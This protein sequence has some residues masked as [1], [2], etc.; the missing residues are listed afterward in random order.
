MIDQA[1]NIEAKI[2]AMILS[3]TNLQE[4]Y[5]KALLVDRQALDEARHSADI[6]RAHR[7]LLDAYATDVRPL[8][9]KVR[10]DLGASAD[11]VAAFRQSGY[12]EK[13]VEERKEGVQAG[14]G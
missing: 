14:W 5:A 7:V 11:P 4:A 9:A 1:H 6:L 2:E 10:E 3:V 8:C 13:V 12:L